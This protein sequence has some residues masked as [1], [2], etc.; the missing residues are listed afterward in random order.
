MICHTTAVRRAKKWGRGHTHWLVW[1]ALLG[2]TASALDV[3]ASANVTLRGY[4]TGGGVRLT[5]LGKGVSFGVEGAWQRPYRTTANEFSLGATLRDLRLSGSKLNAYF[6][7][8]VAFEG[9][10]RHPRPYLEAGLHF[11]VAGNLN[12]RGGLRAYGG[13]RSVSLGVGAE[14]RYSF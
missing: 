7:G 4:G 8:G 3:W 9:L 13:E 5:T 1:G 12:V 2:G 14:W 6:G 10:L 11:P